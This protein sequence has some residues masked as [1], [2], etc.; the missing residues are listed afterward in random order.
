MIIHSSDDKCTSG[1]FY[2]HEISRQSG[3]GQTP[4]FMPLL[5]ENTI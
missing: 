5:M 4:F 2:Q 3:I 1:Q